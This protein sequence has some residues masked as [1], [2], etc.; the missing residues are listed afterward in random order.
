M[1]L[2][3]FV[4]TVSIFPQY[5]ATTS[6]WRSLSIIWIIRIIELRGFYI[7]WD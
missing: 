5:I 6:H 4:G 3:I 2:S 7:S 1:L